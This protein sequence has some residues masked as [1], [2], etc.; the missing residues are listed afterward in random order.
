M[1]DKYKKLVKTIHED[2]EGVKDNNGF[3]YGCLREYFEFYDGRLMCCLTETCIGRGTGANASW[4]EGKTWD[5]IE[6]R[7]N[8]AIA[9]IKTRRE[10]L[11]AKGVVSKKRRSVK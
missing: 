10:H 8:V 6:E 11:I 3:E 5:E 7:V 2:F 4:Y 9:Q 1:T